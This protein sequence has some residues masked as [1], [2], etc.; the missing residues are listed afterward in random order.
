MLCKKWSIAHHL[1]S[2]QLIKHP[3][4][5]IWSYQ[6]RV[7]YMETLFDRRVSMKCLF[8]PV[9]EHLLMSIS[10]FMGINAII[11]VAIY[12]LLLFNHISYIC[13]LICHSLPNL[14]FKPVLV[15]VSLLSFTQP[16][17]FFF[18]KFKTKTVLQILLVL[19]MLTDISL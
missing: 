1:K 14:F 5:G 6:F 10:L 17:V 7:L 13:M 4:I 15:C 11:I 3:T 2:S 12:L 9:F 16:S 19:P 18:V 8:F